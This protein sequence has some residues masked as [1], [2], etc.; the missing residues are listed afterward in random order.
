MFTHTCSN[1]VGEG[2][3]G[4]QSHCCVRLKS[5][6]LRRIIE[7]V[8][9]EVGPFLLPVIFVLPILLVPSRSFVAAFILHLSDTPSTGPSSSGI[10]LADIPAV[11]PVPRLGLAIYPVAQ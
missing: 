10:L 9:V 7:I 4:S 11:P 1:A 6:S 2:L 8:Y 3:S 5:S